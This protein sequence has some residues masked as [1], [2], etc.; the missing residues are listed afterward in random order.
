MSTPVR[1]DLLEPN[2]LILEAQGQN[3]REGNVPDQSAMQLKFEADL[4]HLVQ[5]GDTELACH[6]VVGNLPIARA[7]VVAACKVDAEADT[8]VA[9]PVLADRASREGRLGWLAK[10]RDL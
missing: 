10:S 5:G 4:G 3:R 9:C 1:T 6:A 2:D 8:H 7:V